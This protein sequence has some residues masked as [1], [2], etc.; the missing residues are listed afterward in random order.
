MRHR[1][2]QREAVF[3]RADLAQVERREA[4]DGRARLGRGAAKP[5]ERAV[6]VLGQLRQPGGQA[7]IGQLV[8]GQDELAGR[9]ERP[10][11]RAQA[12]ASSPTGSASGS[13]A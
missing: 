8:A 12:R 2:D 13:V 9:R 10:T 11:A 1:L 7:A 5:V 3:A 4:V 6:V